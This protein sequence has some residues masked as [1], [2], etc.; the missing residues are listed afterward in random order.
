M[1]VPL[2]GNRKV[3]LE[4]PANFIHIVVNGGFPPTTA[5]N[6]RPYGMP[7][8]GPTLKDD[9]IAILASYVRGAWGNAAPPVSPVDVLNAR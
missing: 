5:G 8:F 7:P 1:Y 4:T 2:A 6:P 9:E 3:L